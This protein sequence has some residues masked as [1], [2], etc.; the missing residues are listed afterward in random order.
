MGQSNGQMR[1]PAGQSGIRRSKA[2]A[3]S[4]EAEARRYTRLSLS[5]FACSDAGG[6]RNGTHERCELSLPRGAKP[7]R[8]LQLTQTSHFAEK[9]SPMGLTSEGSSSWNKRLTSRRVSDSRTYS[10][11]MLA[12]GASNFGTS[13]SVTGGTP[14]EILR[15]NDS[16]TSPG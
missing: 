3:G 2:R 12:R 8:A 11:T 14:S 9:I 1:I 13:G 16:P 15:A 5:T 10:A 7:S 6:N 4:S